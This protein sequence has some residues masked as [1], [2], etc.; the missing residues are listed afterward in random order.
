MRGIPATSSARSSSTLMPS[1]KWSECASA[2]SSSLQVALNFCVW[3][4][5]DIALAV[6]RRRV[7]MG[8]ASGAVPPANCAR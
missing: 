8:V 3:A 4:S 7:D 5:I 1:T 2:C 6:R